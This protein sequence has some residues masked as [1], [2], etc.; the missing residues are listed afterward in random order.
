MLD[1]L[2]KFVKYHMDPDWAKA[3]EIKTT[4]ASMESASY[5]DVLCGLASLRI[6]NPVN[7]KTIMWRNQSTINANIMVG[8][9][10]RYDLFTIKS[11]YLGNDSGGIKKY[12]LIINFTDRRWDSDDFEELRGVAVSQLNEL[13]KDILTR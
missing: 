7:D 2:R 8:R 4:E 13:T 12:Q 1:L 9:V 10:G 6:E 11:N 3:Q 5:I